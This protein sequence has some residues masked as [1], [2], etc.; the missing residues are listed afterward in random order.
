MRAYFASIWECRNFWFSLVVND[1]QL[2]Y[3]RSA[4]G[5]GWSLL[6]PLASAI[7]LGAV[8]HVIFHQPVRE[9]L[10]FLLCG[11]AAW[12]FVTGVATEGCSSYI[13]AENDI[14]QHPLPIAVYPLR[15]TLGTM[16]HFLIALVLV[17]IL[18]LGLQGLSKPPEMFSLTLGILLL[19][20]FGW[21]VAILTGFLNVAFR[22][23]QHILGIVFQ[24]WFYVTPIIYP[25]SSI[26]STSIGWVLAINPLTPFVDLIR[27]PMLEG[28][29]ASLA[30]YGAA[31]L[32]TLVVGAAAVLTLG[33]QQRRVIF[34][35]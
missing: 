6:Y 23:T 18:K 16:I 34:Y 15:T 5:V 22:D 12:S 30:C 11:L 10:P 1:L 7:V 25:A 4:L 20:V 21:V 17:V 32:I 8:F 31:V 33:A 14:R 13:S 19:F 29:P 3:R 9:Y 2:R 26:S 35:L 24:I 28:R 27:E